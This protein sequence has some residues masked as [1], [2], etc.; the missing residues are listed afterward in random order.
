MQ[1]A[2]GADHIIHDEDAFSVHGIQI[3]TVDDE[4]LH[5]LGRNGNILHHNRLL[6][7]K[8]WA[9]PGRDITFAALAA[10]LVGQRDTFRFGRNDN[11]KLRHFFQQRFGA[12]HSK[13]H[14][15]EHHKRGN[16]QLFIHRAQRQLP[17]NAGN[18][19]RIS[20]THN[21]FSFFM[22]GA[23][24]STRRPCQA[25]LCQ[26]M[27]MQMRHALSAVPATVR[28]NAVSV[29]KL[30]VFG[31]PGNHL[32]DMRYHSAVLRRNAARRSDVCFGDHEKM[33]RCLRIDIMKRK[34]GV[35]F[36]HLADRDIPRRHL[37][38]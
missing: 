17:R 2:A 38:K 13:L 8:F 28:H 30:Q 3:L 31:Q 20:F 16:V 29:S 14:I 34:H 10:H 4:L 23:R 7:V 21:S 6:H 22:I 24:H 12:G 11:I 37:A 32:K 36:I 33:H 9:F 35:I 5:G 26:H 27:K 18:I 15:T 1:A 19:Q 25:A